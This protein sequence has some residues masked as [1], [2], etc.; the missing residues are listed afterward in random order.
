M[1]GS[2]QAFS[3]NT[4]GSWEL[5]D[6]GHIDASGQPSSLGLTNTYGINTTNARTSGNSSTFGAAG[7]GTYDTSGLPYNERYH[8]VGRR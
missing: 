5:F 4:G 7:L 8:G 6:T 2:M 3:G 1:S